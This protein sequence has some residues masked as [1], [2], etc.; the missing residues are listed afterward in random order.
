MGQHADIG[1]FIESAY[2]WNAV[3]R[4]LKDE[5]E[6][7]SAIDAGRLFQSGIVRYTVPLHKGDDFLLA[8][9]R[10]RLSWFRGRR[11]GLVALCIPIKS[12]GMAIR[13]CNIL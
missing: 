6:S 10:C 13:L 5:R 8:L 9:G 7:A 4:L 2:G 11:A 3:S 12:G 1:L